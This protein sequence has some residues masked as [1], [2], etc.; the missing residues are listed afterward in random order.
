MFENLIAQNAKSLLADDIARGRLP[1]SILLSGSP[2]S[3][4]LTAA[5]EIAR[6]LSCEAPRP[7]GAVGSPA[8]SMAPWGCQ[9]PSCRKHKELAHPDLLVVGPRDCALEVRA[10]AAAFARARSKAAQYLFIR[11]VRK[12]T[13]RFS[14][15]L[16][17]ESDQRLSKAAPLITDIEE[18]IE[19]LD[20]SRDP[21]SDASKAEKAIGSLVLLAEKLEAEF[22][23]DSL[24]VAQVRAASSWAW[25]SPAGKKKVLV[26]E[27]ADRMQEGARNAFLKTLEEPPTNAVFVLTTARRGAVLP[28]IL[29]R[30]RTYAFVDRSETEESEVVERVF[31]DRAATGES[32]SSYFNR[33]LPVPPDS[34][35]L[36][37]ARF[38]G[39]VLARSIDEGRRPLP[40]TRA[41]LD[42]RFAALPGGEAASRLGPPEA[43]ELVAQ[44]AKCQPRAIYR[45]FVASVLRVLRDALRS[46]STDAR[47]T[48]VLSSWT[49]AARDA[50][51]AVSVYNISPT[52]ALESLADRMR[53][54]V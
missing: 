13:L 24:P 23:Y 43:G 16:A 45:L 6:A 31:H 5:L 8:A 52:S 25:L 7:A 26:V 30:V 29:S 32:L 49:K 11:S 37:G 14:P 47:E 50:V 9:C 33:F 21:W 38:L 44:L 22:L 46:G 28:T 27:N 17:D 54:A 15:Q 36:A 39:G 48:A 35:A 20:P 1:P 3:G 18:G 2:A 10:A 41:A 51:D 4:K 40:A 12:L 34:I 53:E 42:A 19:E